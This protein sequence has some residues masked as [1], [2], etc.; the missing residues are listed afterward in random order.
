MSRNYINFY[1][2]SA[3]KFVKVIFLKCLPS[4]YPTVVTLPS[5][6]SGWVALLLDQDTFVTLYQ[7]LREPD[8]HS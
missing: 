3:P 4:T 7:G 1:Q 5:L 6:Q 2:N 8:I